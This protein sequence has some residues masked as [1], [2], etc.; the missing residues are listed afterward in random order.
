ME[1]ITGALL[2]AVV[3]LA[4]DKYKPKKAKVEEVNDKERELQK[5]FDELMNYTPE[6]AYKKV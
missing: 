3:I 1:F 4:Y 6:K 5:H 2:M